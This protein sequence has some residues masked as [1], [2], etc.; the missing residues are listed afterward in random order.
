MDWAPVRIG[1]LRYG[2]LKSSLRYQRCC[3]A[4]VEEEAQVALTL[5]L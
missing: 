3:S 1:S 2:G 4:Q 5:E